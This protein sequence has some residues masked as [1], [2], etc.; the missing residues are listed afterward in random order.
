MAARPKTDP[1]PI[2]SP[3]P[4]DRVPSPNLPNPIRSIPSP[5]RHAIPNHPSPSRRA[6]LRPIRQ[7]KLR[8]IRHR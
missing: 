1:N 5:N 4:K 3:D 7:P 2:P 6:N 8:A